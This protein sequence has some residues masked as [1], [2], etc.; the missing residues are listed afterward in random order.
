MLLKKSAVDLEID[1]RRQ[2]S[3]LE[4]IDAYIEHYGKGREE[5]LVKPERSRLRRFKE[6]LI[7]NKELVPSAG[8][9]S[10]FAINEYAKYLAGSTKLKWSGEGE[11]AHQVPSQRP[12][13][14][15]SLNAFRR[16]AV[17]C[18][19]WASREKYVTL[20]VHEVSEAFPQFKLQEIKEPECLSPDQLK[21]LILAVE[22]HDTDRFHGS[23]QDK[24]AYYTGVQSPVAKKKHKE[25]GPLL[26][27]YMLTGVRLGEALHLRWE[28]VDWNRKIVRLKPDRN[29]GWKIKTKRER[30]IP[31]ADSPLL[32]KLLSALQLKANG[33][34]YIIA[35]SE[36]QPRRFDRRSWD[37][38][39]NSAGL[40]FVTPQI[41][42][43][44]FA[45]ALAAAKE[46][47]SPYELAYRMGHRVTVAERYYVVHVS[48]CKGSTVEEWL[49]IKE[50]LEKCL[51]ALNLLPTLQGQE[52]VQV[53]GAA[54]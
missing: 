22:T 29:T 7:A 30:T 38:L 2:L 51:T 52:K 48:P 26:L 53:Y 39:A 12:L 31:F 11:K 41:L 50:E 43:S 20:S 28:N 49:G 42:R 44:T 46:G 37:S 27:V 14:G 21:R 16:A 40:G 34:P 15:E 35:G 18:L 8:G 24:N 17:A 25:I 9:L 32:E 3:M 6:W 36:G 10:P 33:S 54:E 5:R 47:P 1:R 23:R 45:S 4:V 13:A 19:R